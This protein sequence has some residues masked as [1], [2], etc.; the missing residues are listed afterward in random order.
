MNA[1]A[2][3]KAR[4][5]RADE[6]QDYLADAK[7]FSL[8]GEMKAANRRTARLAWLV[9]GTGSLIGVAG[10]I[11]AATLF[12]LKHTDLRYIEVDT[13]TGYIGDSVGVADAPKLFSEQVAH[14]YLRMYIEA[15]ETYVPQTDALQ[16]ARVQVMSA[17]DERV[18]F[19]AWHKDPLS[20]AQKLGRTG[21]VEV[22]N[23]H[24]VLQGK[25]RAKTL[26]YFVRFKRRET[27]GATVGPWEDWTATVQFQFHPEMGMDA[28]ERQINPAGMQVLA[29]HSYKDR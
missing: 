3:W 14:Q 25:G 24:P 26:E 7:A 2:R 5:L 8:L 10:V 15:R 23:F 18:R 1:I 9:G 6:R 19:A 11:C 12:P 22:D 21:H 20:P 29:Y 4:P 28:Q 17:E 27:Q 16:F 13:S